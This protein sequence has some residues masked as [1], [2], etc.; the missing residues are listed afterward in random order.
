MV[1]G[2]LLVQ[3]YDCAKGNVAKW[4][5]A[6]AAANAQETTA[7]ETQR[8]KDDCNITPRHCQETIGIIAKAA[9]NKA[10]AV[11]DI[12]KAG[13]AGLTSSA[14]PPPPRPDYRQ[15]WRGRPARC[16]EPGW[17]APCPPLAR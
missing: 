1:I 2:G 6:E 7:R 8:L 16:G 10:I 13:L 14:A 15:Q 12:P 3:S 4:A 17:T 9:R 5:A 11:S